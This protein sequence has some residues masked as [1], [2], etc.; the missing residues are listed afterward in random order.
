MIVDDDTIQ[1][2]STKDNKV[3]GGFVAEYSFEIT[4]IE[5]LK[6]INI[7]TR[8]LNQQDQSTFFITIIENYEESTS[9]KKAISPKV[10]LT[11]LTIGILLFCVI[12]I[13]V[14]VKFKR[15]I[16]PEFE[17]LTESEEKYLAIV[18]IRKKIRKLVKQGNEENVDEIERL[19][20]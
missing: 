18:E 7:Y 9:D 2:K 19:Q 17:P 11:L 8:N 1:E 14:F 20:V 4:E 12:S 16:I 3:D 13:L 5:K 6:E 10:V 15:S